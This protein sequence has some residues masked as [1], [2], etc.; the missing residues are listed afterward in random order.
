METLE[1][2]RSKLTEKG[3]YNVTNKQLITEWLAHDCSEQFKFGLTLMPKKIFAGYFK[4]K[5]RDRH[6]Y[7]QELET[8]SNR[9]VDK[10]NSLV[11]TK[12]YAR[13][14]KKLAVVMTIEGERSYKDLHTHFALSKP[15]TMSCIE[16]AKRVREALELSGDFCT[17]DPNFKFDNS[18]FN[19]KYRYKLDI[20][21]DGWLYYITKELDKHNIHNLYLP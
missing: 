20:T 8:A 11:Y 19:E 5:K 15:S 4:G 17:D 3:A 9:F 2:I 10:L 13:Y 12:A 7:K 18:K 14:N 21:D 1:E 16:F 6:L